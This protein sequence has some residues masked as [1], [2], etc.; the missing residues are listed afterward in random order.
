MAEAERERVSGDLWRPLETSG[1]CVHSNVSAVE[2]IL[3]TANINK[4]D[5]RR[6]ERPSIDRG[7]PHVA[8]IIFTTTNPNGP[9]VKTITVW[10]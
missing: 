9:E 7:D 8:I 10:S 1:L 2:L 5:I 6:P 3:P 4:H